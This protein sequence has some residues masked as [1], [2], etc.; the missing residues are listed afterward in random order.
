MH[1]RLDLKSSPPVFKKYK[2]PHTR[3]H[4]T[5][6]EKEEII[7]KF[8]KLMPTPDKWKEMKRRDRQPKKKE[9]LKKLKINEQMFK[10]LCRKLGYSKKRER[11]IGRRDNK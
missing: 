9:C 1:C 4:Y 5:A 10:N 3:R 8:K 2:K 11:I 7:I 6:G